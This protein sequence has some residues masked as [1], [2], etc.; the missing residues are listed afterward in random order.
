MDEYSMELHTSILKI[1]K[2]ITGCGTGERPKTSCKE[3]FAAHTGIDLLNC[4]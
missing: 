1:E 4:C 2:R 3:N